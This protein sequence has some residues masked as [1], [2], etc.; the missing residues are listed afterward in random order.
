MNS[1]ILFSALE[2]FSDI[3]VVQSILPNSLNEICLDCFL[4]NPIEYG[5][6]IDNLV[7]YV[8][9]ES[10]YL[11][12]PPAWHVEQ[13]Y[14]VLTEDMLE[15]MW[16]IHWAQAREI[17][18]IIEQNKDLDCLFNKYLKENNFA[19]YLI[20]SEDLEIQKDPFYVFIRDRDVAGV[21]FFTKYF[22]MFW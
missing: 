10:T 9:C 4:N 5:D 11:P 1:L 22:G 17:D 13:S 6:Y 18:L 21:D 19:H 8:A 15:Q 3:P 7:C 16:F 12:F 2:Q 14:K 20:A